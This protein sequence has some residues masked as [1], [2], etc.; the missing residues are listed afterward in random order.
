SFYCLHFANCKSLLLKYYFKTL[1]KRADFNSL[2]TTYLRFISLGFL[3]SQMY[4]LSTIMAMT[5]TIHFSANQFKRQLPAIQLCMNEPTIKWQVHEFYERLTTTGIGIGYY[6]GRIA[7]INYHNS[8]QLLMSYFGLMLITFT[9]L[10]MLFDRIKYYN[11]FEQLLDPKNRQWFINEFILL[12]IETGRFLFY[13]ILSFMDESVL[14]SY[15]PYD[16]TAAPL[17]DYFN[18]LNDGTSLNLNDCRIISIILLI[19]LIFI[20]YSHYMLYLTDHELIAWRLLYDVSNRNYDHYRDS[21]IAKQNINITKTVINAL[22]NDNNN[23]YNET[24]SNSSPKI[25]HNSLARILKKN[26]KSFIDKLIIQFM[27]DIDLY[28][29]EKLRLKIFSYAGLEQR[30]AFVMTMSILDFLDVFLFILFVSTTLSFGCLKYFNFIHI[31]MWHLWPFAIFDCINHLYCGYILLRNGILFFNFASI[32]LIFFLSQMNILNKNIN[33]LFGKHKHLTNCINFRL[34]YSRKSFWRRFQRQHQHM[35]YCIMSSGHDVWNNMYLMGVMANIPLNIVCI[36]NLVFKSNSLNNEFISLGF[37][38]SQM[39]ILSTIMAMTSTIHFSANQFKRQLP[40]LQLCMNEPTIKWQVHEFYE[41]LTTTGIGIGYYCGRI[42]LIN[43]HNSFQLL[44][45]YFGLMLITFMD[46]SVLRSYCPYDTTAAPLFDYFNHLNDGTSLN[47]NDCRITSII[48]TIFFIFILHCQYVIFLID[49]NSLAY[50]TLYDV[51]IRNYDYF[52]DSIIHEKDNNLIRTVLKILNNS[53]NSNDFIESISTTTSTSPKIIHNSLVKMLKKNRKSFI[54]KFFIYLMSNIDLYKFEKLRLK[55]FTYAGLEQR[56]AFVMTMLILDFLNVFLFILGVSTTLSFG[57]FKYFNFIRIHMWNLWPFAIF[58]CINHLYCGYILLRNGILFFNF[59]SI[60][61]IYNLVFKSNSLNNEFISLGFLISQMYIL[62]ASIAMMSTINFSVNQFK[63]QLSIVQLCMKEPTIKWQVNEFYERLTTKE[64][65]FGFYLG[66]I[67]I[68][69]YRNTFELLMSYFGLMLITFTFLMNNL[70]IYTLFRGSTMFFDRLKYYHQFEQLLDPKNHQWWQCELILITIQTGRF[71]FYV[72]L[73]F[74]NES[75]LR[76]YCPYDT[77]AA[78]LFDYFNHLNNG[79][80][81]NLNDCRITSIIF[82]I[83]F[84]FILHSQYMLFF[85]DHKLITWRLLYDVS[86]RNYDYY[87]DSIIAKQN[88]NITETVVKALFSRNDFD[89]PEPNSSSSLHN[90]LTKML[91]KS[92]KSFIDNLIIQLM[93]NIDLHKFEKLKLK[94]FS[95]TGLKLRIKLALSMFVLHCLDVFMLTLVISTTLNLACLNY[96]NFI[97]IHMWN[98]WPLALIDCINHC[99]C[100]YIFFRNGV[101]YFNL[102]V[103]SLM[104][105]AS[106]MNILN[107]KI[108][109][110][111]CHRRRLINSRLYYLRLLIWRQFQRQHQ[112]MTYCIMYS[113]HDVWNNVFFMGVMANVPLNIMLIYNLVFKTNSLN[114]E[115][116]YLIFL[117]FQ[118]YILCAIMLNAST[119]HFSFHQFKRQLPIIQLCMKEFSIKWQVNEFYERLTTKGI[120]FGY[121]LGGIAIINY[122][123][124]FELLISYFGFMLIIIY[125]LFR[126]S[127]MFFDRLKYYHQFEQVLDRNNR[128]WWICELWLLII[129]TGRFL[130]YVILSFMDES[131]IRSYCPYDTTAAPLFNY[132]Y[133]QNNGTSLNITDSRI[134]SIILLIFYIYILHSQYMIYLTDRNLLTWHFLND[135]SNRNY[136]HYHNS[137]INEQNMNMTKMIIKALSNSNDFDEPKPNSSSSSLHNCLIKMLKKNRKNFF[138]KLIIQLMLNIDLYKFE[139]LHLKYFNYIGLKQRI[140]LI[141]TMFVLHCMNVFLSTLVI[142][143]TLNLGCV[144]YFNFIRIHMWNLW[145]FAIIDCI[146][147]L[148]CGYIFI[149]NSLLYFNFSAISLISLKSQMN[150]LNRKLNHVFGTCRHLMNFRFYYLRLFIWRKFQRQHQ[151]MTYCIMK[152]GNDIFNDVYFVGV[153]ANIPL[154]IMCIYDLVFRYDSLNNRFMYLGFSFSQIFVLSNILTNASTINFSSHQFK[155]QLPII[156]LCM[157]E[158]TIKWQINEFYERLTTTDN[159]FG[160]YL[161]RIAI[162]NYRNTFQLLISYLGRFLFYVILSFMDESVLR[163][164]CPFDTTAAPLFH[165]FTHFNDG[166][167]LNLN[168]CRLTSIILTLYFFFILH[169]HYI[170]FLTNHILLSWSI[171]YDVSNRNYDHYRNSIINEQ[172]MNVTKMIIKALSNSNDFDEPKPNSSSSS[173][174]LHNCLKKLL[175]KNRKSLID[176]LFI[177]VMLNIDLFKF[178]KLRLKVLNYTGLKQRIALAMTMSI[179]HCIDVFL[180]TLVIFTTLNLGCL[181]YFNFIRIHMWNLWPFAIIDCIN[182]LYC[183]YIFIRNSLLY[184]NISSIGLIFY[185]S[186]LNSLNKMI[187]D[188]FVNRRHIMNSRLNYLRQLVWRQFQRQHQHMTYCMMYSGHDLWNDV[189]FIGIMANI[190]LNIMCIYNLV[191]RNDSLNN[192]FMYLG[193]LISQMFVLSAIMVNASTMH[194]SANQFKRQLPIIQLGMKKPSIKWQVNEFYERLTTTEIGFGFYCGRIGIINYHNSFHILISYFA[195]MLIIFMDESVLRSYCSYDTTA[196]PLFDYFTHL[197]DG[198]S[199]NL[200]DCRLTSLIILIFFIFV[201]YSDFKIFVTDHELTLAWRL[202]YDLSNRNYDYY[203]SSIVNEQNMNITKMLMLNI[204]LYE[205]KKLRLKIFPYAGLKQRIALAMTMIILHYMDVFWFILVISTSVNF[206]CLKYFNF[207]RIHMMNLWPFAIIDCIN[208]LYCSYIVIRNALLYC[209]VSSINFIFN[210][211]QM[212]SLNRK[213]KQVFGNRRHMMNS[214]LNYLRQLVWRQFQRQHQ[215]ITHCIMYGGM[216]IWNG[217]LFMGIIANIPLNIMCIYNIVFKYNSLNNGFMYLGFILSQTFSLSIIIAI[218]SEVNFSA[219]QFKRQLP[220]IQSCMK[221]PTIKWQVNEFYERLTTSGQGFGFYCGRIA[222]INYHNSFQLLLFY[223]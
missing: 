117:I 29:F 200:N 15:C 164:Y 36:Y 111:F 183:G 82:F 218:L 110:I 141:L 98:L 97:Q 10:P 127:T 21:I 139:K 5:S 114:K 223:S 207:I 75:V 216:E 220:I 205:F 195:F 57:C 44:I 222:I 53:H 8:F 118:M 178:N 203:R 28:K 177:Q 190:P 184:F 128:K 33:K 9:F 7:L 39:Y 43:Y 81:L 217:V 17:F 42:A 73:S 182:H 198:T 188:L 180:S 93:L 213:L 115:F 41:R 129:Q 34:N 209:N 173:S 176:K 59:A 86:N 137:I 105:F 63:R 187:N 71:L 27:L 134:T 197:N 163:S 146:N 31:H 49:R 108:I 112:H 192:Q 11:Q 121:Y 24:I 83:I 50:R 61:C 102:S 131:V 32:S 104:F 94:V 91:K 48:M 174:S 70:R 56:I 89:E 194:F 6:C 68:I 85:T 144:Q 120:G 126:I 161:G 46:E 212:N 65:G 147:H 116:M 185:A 20:Q 3:S 16:T 130:F 26:P 35:T 109:E 159:G 208:H 45:S 135:L 162:I 219:H 84:I 136:D 191:F 158:L 179:L 160:F 169:S 52:N 99:Y 40:V 106:Q 215:H 67:A 221:K 69:N 132:F 107:K 138:D 25:M 76:S 4:I 87:R 103:M 152:S 62:S 47:L 77:T 1:K 193:F 154:N 168:D 140:E 150:S 125:T 58:D 38:S 202:L 100:T 80:P 124:T 113:G 22:S 189:Y 37:L 170:L 54:D 210:V 142:F 156:Q 96:F 186:Q 12:T 157:K 166:T 199:L 95:Y 167:P 155:R 143:T 23:K 153:M 122:R 55:I 88:I 18:H 206:G 90:C 133:H 30:I 14:R 181:K 92:H 60:I 2:R 204:N 13:V 211:L 201:L 148:Y 214:R 64:N 79:T 74:M 66:R 175:T 72:I 145:P 196:A 19:F 151:H 101:L 119:M 171:L 165:Y 123:N 172:N 78:P 149:R 51:S